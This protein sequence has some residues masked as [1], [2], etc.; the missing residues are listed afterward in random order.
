M[1]QYPVQDQPS[2][3]N[4][5]NLLLSGPGGLGQNY[6]GVSDY[7]PAYLRGTFRQPFSVTITTGTNA[8]PWYTSPVGI[9]NIVGQNVIDGKSKN[10]AV[11]L[12]TATSQPLF[13]AGDRVYIHDVNPDFYNDSWT[14]LTCT[15]STVQI[16][17]N[18]SYTWPPY[19][20]G[21]NIHKDNSDEF[22][23]TDANARVTITG[24]TEQ[25]FI[26]GQ[27][28]MDFTYT[29]TTAS[30]FDVVVAVNRYI[31]SVDQTSVGATDYYF[32]LDSTLSSQTK[33]YSV[34]SSGSE[35]LSTVFSTVIDK[36]NFGYY[37]YIIEISFNTYDA[38]GTAYPGDIRPGTFTENFRSLIAQ[39]IKQ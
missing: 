7:A 37:W 1:S 26:S 2:L 22:V 18:N 36:P 5:V 28:N 11:T 12:T 33:H 17:T 39:V 14:V 15:T 20:S 10:I 25:A 35:T 4:A 32:N 31:G 3:I 13:I 19:V 24:P 9:S 34:A 16:Q 8:I 23:S 27:L 6:S 38:N 29:C 30:Q 21:G